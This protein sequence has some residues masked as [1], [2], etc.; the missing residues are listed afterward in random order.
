MDYE[1]NNFA[2]QMPERGAVYQPFPQGQNNRKMF[3]Q[4]AQIFRNKMLKKSR[5]PWL[6]SLS[7]GEPSI[8][9]L[10]IE[11]QAFQQ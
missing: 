3:G 5:A 2:Y 11:I 6:Q 1:G 8:N 10:Y 9:G 4:T 7:L